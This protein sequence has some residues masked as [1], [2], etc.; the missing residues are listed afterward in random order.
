M[1]AACW[2]DAPKAREAC[3]ALAPKDG[4]VGKFTPPAR[5]FCPWLYE[6]VTISAVGV[7]DDRF[8]L[9][10]QTFGNSCLLSSS[11]GAVAGFASLARVPR[12]PMAGPWEGRERLRQA[13]AQSA[14]PRLNP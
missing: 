8:S 5:T 9:S 10:S 1:F 4:D 12:S 6:P 7:W 13:V 11:L 2:R 14:A 3:V